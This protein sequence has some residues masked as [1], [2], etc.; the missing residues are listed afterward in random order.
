MV[1]DLPCCPIAPF[2]GALKSPKRR[3]N[4]DE[5]AFLSKRLR[6]VILCEVRTPAKQSETALA[7]LALGDKAFL[8]VLASQRHTQVG[9]RFVDGILLFSCQ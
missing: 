9:R 6:T 8:V 4:S 7:V 5:V 2:Q 3:R 1:T